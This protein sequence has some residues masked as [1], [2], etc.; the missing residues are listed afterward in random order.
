MHRHGLAAV[1]HR[2]VEVSGKGNTLWHRITA[3]RQPDV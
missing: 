1:D 2:K 3:S